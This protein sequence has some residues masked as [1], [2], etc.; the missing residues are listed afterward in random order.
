MQ[1]AHSLWY[2][3]FSQYASQELVDA[4]FLRKRVAVVQDW[5]MHHTPNGIPAL[6]HEEVLSGINT[7]DATV[8]PQQIGQACSFNPELAELKTLQTGTA[9]RKMGGVLSLSPMVDVCRTPSFNRLEESYGEDGYLS[10]VM[11]T[12]FVKG[13]QQA[14][15]GREWELALNTIWDMV[16]AV[17]LMRR[18]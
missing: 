16:V 13:L 8:Y 1:A 10:A 5:L 3:T 7:Q 12:A 9:L 4:N 11:G 6:F 14:T 17:M 18:R 15:S 2:W